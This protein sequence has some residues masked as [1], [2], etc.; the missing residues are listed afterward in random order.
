MKDLIKQ[1]LRE[2]VEIPVRVKRRLNIIDD[3]LP[4]KVKYDY[5]PK[6]VCKYVSDEEFIDVVKDSV[7]DNIY[8]DYFSDM[9]ENSEEWVKSFRYMEKYIN[10][11]YGDELKKHYHLNCGD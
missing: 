1:I 4:S 11:V 10:D 9:D 7:I 6:S 8:W 3:L 5:G 2:E